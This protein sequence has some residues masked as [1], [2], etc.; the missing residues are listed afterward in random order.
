MIIGL[1]LL[2][3]WLAGQSL[4]SYLEFPPTPEP[5]ESRPFSWPLFMATALVVVMVVGPLVFRVITAGDHTPGEAPH[6]ISF[7]RWGWLGLGI[8]TIAWILAWNRFSWFAPL[9]THTFTPLWMGYILV[10]NA[11]TFR[12]TGHCLLVDRPA[13]FLILFPLSAIFWWFFEYLNLFAQN[14]YYVGGN[15]S[16]GGIRDFLVSSLPFSTVLPA[17]LSTWYLLASFPRLSAGLG[18]FYRVPVSFPH[19]LPWMIL[20]VGAAGLLGIGIWPEYL[21]P[22]LWVAHLVRM[23]ALQSRTGRGALF[24]CLKQGD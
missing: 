16:T 15:D 17:V 9:Q 19:W 1:P 8:V 23:V 11:L 13:I 20:L 4:G 18:D 14:W 12:R 24:S 5:W 3:T 6:T 2:G 7:S 22:A 10:V 21:F